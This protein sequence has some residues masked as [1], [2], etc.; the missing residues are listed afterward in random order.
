M[1]KLFSL[2]TATSILI[3][4]CTKSVNNPQN[5]NNNISTVVSKEFVVTKLT[6]NSSGTNKSSIFSGYTFTF[7]A[8]GTISA[9]KNSITEQGSYTQKPSHEGEG[10]KLTITFS[11]AP[12]NELN[13]QWQIDLISNNSIHLSDDGNASE[14]LQFA[15]K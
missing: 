7:N 5:N 8:D 9:V 12:L 13:K 2:I 15:A 10:A 4:S 3:A 14:V 11:N 1:K 6:D